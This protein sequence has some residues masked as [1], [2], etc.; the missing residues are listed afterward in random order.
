MTGLL[1]DLRYGLRQLRKN[2]GFTAVALLTLA[3]GI[4]ANTGIFTLVNAVLLKSLPVP[5]PEQLFLV[6]QSSRYAENTRFSYPVFQNMQA[7]MPQSASL[8]AMT[9]PADFYASVGN[10][11]PEMVEGQLVSGNY[12]ETLQTYAA[13]GRLLTPDDDRV[14]GGSPVAV[15]SY[16]CWERR[17]GGDPGV[18]GRKM[19]VNGMPF[20]V[21]GVAAPGF[22]GAKAGT[23]PDFWLPITMQSA[24]HYAQHYSQTEAADLDKPWVLQPDIRWLQFIVRAR[25]RN[26]LPM[27]ATAVNQVFRQDLERDAAGIKD[28]QER[29]A[30]LRARLELEPGS[31]GLSTL[32]RSFERPLLVLMAM[33]GLVLLIACANLANLFLARAAAR[34]REMAVRLSVGASRARLFRQTLAECLLLSIFGGLL[35]IAVAYWCSAIFPKWASSGAAPIPLSLAPD[36]R[37]LIFSTVVAVLT[38]LLFGLAPAVQGTR[39]E[40]VRALKANARGFSGSGSMGGGWSF[41]QALVASQVALS[42]VLLVGAGLFLRTLRNFT[43]LDPGFDSGHIL[44]VWLDTHMGGYKQEQLPSL[45]QRLIERVEA[46]PGVRAAAL[47]SC[48]LAVGCE[49]SSDIYLPGVPH[50]NGETDSQERRVSQHYLATAGIPLLG[51]RDFATTDTEKSPAVA[52]VNQAFVHEFLHD[53]NPIGQYFGYDSVNDHRFQ[54]V[55]EVKDA[56]VNDIRESPPPMIYHSV[57]QDVIDVESLDVR[58]SGDPEQSI[59]G[60]REAVRSVDPNL[61]IGGITTVSEELANDL[62]QQRLIA[63][64]TAIFGALALGLACL[65][66]YG[67]MSYTVARRT[68]ELGIRLAVGASRT[69]V[70]W[71][72]LRQTLLVIGAGVAAGLLLSFLAGRAITSLL[73]GL[74][75]YDPVTVT[76]AAAMLLLVSVGSGLKPAWRAAHVNPTEALRV[77]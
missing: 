22:L 13:L 40:P 77:E 50:T 16:G 31:R 64:L 69:A 1:Q 59:S 6:R 41:K 7:A 36:A 51:G 17:F 47:A 11:Q 45:Y 33:V 57:A 60:V 29:L 32:R 19:L 34:E 18:I 14:V 52:I 49:D 56:R 30:F 5:N 27:I 9:W 73:F 38:G 43:E 39:V 68:S 61:P 37:V 3:L 35:G 63:R 62:A 48:G 54:I 42:L 2:P 23:A 66:L 46:V 67:V 26:A 8:A 15:V 24:V 75:P 65:G 10:G 12:F 72:V 55:G 20:E 28:P 53:K 25:D 76:G 44:T 4:G 70:L 71:L 74:S 21:V 58:T